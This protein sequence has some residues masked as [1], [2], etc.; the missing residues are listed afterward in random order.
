MLWLASSL[1]V[2]YKLTRRPHSLAPEP[3]PAVAWATIEPVRLNTDDGLE[4]GAWYMPGRP[5][6]PSFV[7]LHGFRSRRDESLPLA[8][9]L[10]NEGCSVLAVTMRAHGDSE[11]NYNDVGYSARHDVAAAVAWLEQ[12]RPGKPVFVQGTSMGAA[13]AIYAAAELQTRVR[14]YILECP[15]DDIRSAVRN[16][17]SG[18]LPWPLDSVAYAGLRLVGPIFLPDLDRMAPVNYVAAIPETVPV[19]VMTG[20]RDRRARPAEVRAVYERIA[21]HARL[22]VFPEADHGHLA[23]QCGAAYRAAV[24]DFLQK[25]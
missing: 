6:G 21:S 16:R 15:F 7:L 9:T 10:A 8:E 14:G 11:G 23:E 13:A 1:A 4:L 25:K 22:V 12:R 2:A 18:H 20:G 3:P 19:L 17:V 5:D 24:I